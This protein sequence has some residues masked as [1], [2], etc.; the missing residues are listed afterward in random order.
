M[1]DA[2]RGKNTTTG[3]RQQQS[4][5]CEQQIPVSKQPIAAL[6]NTQHKSQLG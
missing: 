6:G 2:M 4:V 5:V 1:N 3:N